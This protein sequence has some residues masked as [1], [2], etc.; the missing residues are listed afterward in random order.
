LGDDG[1]LR[2]GK[3]AIIAEKMATL[4]AWR[5]SWKSIYEKKRKTPNG[6]LALSGKSI[7]EAAK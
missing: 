6:V 1:N 7:E 5:K 2:L 4:K 3:K